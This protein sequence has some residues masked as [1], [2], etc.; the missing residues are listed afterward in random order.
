V[1]GPSFRI[2]AKA[3]VVATLVAIVVLAART[4]DQWSGIRW[5]M[6]VL[7]ATVFLGMVV[8]SWYILTGKTTVDARGIHQDW[9]APKRYA[10]DEIVRARRIR[11]VV[12]SRLMISTGHGPMK[13]IHGGSPELDAAFAEIAA[14]YRGMPPPA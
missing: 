2:A 12:T 7:L 9:M 8:T 14:Y 13:A 6:A 3:T 5:P 10:W 1:S 11:L 4:A